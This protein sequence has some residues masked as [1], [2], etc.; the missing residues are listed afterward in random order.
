MRRVRVRF[1]SIILAFC[2]ALVILGCRSASSLPTV[3]TEVFSPDGRSL[4]VFSVEVAATNEERSKGLMFRRELG[5]RQGMLF[6]FPKPG[7]L[8]F[9]MKNTLIP[10]DMIFVSSDWR[11]VGV[12]AN[13]VPLTEDPRMVEGESQYVLEFAGGTAAREGIVAGGKVAVKGTLPAAR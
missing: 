5:A 8:S 6:L 2:V 3:D 13:A 1:S 7:R 10:L 11:V 9:W 12:V 4:G